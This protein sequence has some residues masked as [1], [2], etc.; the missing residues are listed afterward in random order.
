MDDMLVCMNM[1][2]GSDRARGRRGTN[3]SSVSAGSRHGKRVTL[4]PLQVN[5]VDC[6]QDTGHTS[7]SVHDDAEAGWGSCGNAPVPAASRATT[8]AARSTSTTASICSGI[9]A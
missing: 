1:L 2:G 4:R 6:W 3:S 9:D 8:E 7:Q 5:A